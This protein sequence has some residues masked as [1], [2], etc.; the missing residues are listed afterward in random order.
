VAKKLCSALVAY[1][2]QFPLLWPLSIRHLVCCLAAHKV[3]PPTAV[4]HTVQVG[5]DILSLDPRRAYGVLWFATTLADEAG[6]LDMSSAKKLVP[7]PSPF[8]GR[9][10]T[11][12]QIHD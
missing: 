12:V 3:C 1:L 10:H 11:T 2:L 6:K 9:C 5:I 8:D 4:D 7:Y